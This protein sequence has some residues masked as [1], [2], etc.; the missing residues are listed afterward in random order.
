MPQLAMLD[1][2]AFNLDDISS[3]LICPAQPFGG[4]GVYEI[5]FLTLD[6]FSN[7]N[8]CVNAQQLF[9]LCLIR[10]VFSFRQ[11]NRALHPRLIRCRALESC[12][13][14]RITGQPYAR[15]RIEV[16]A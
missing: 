15:A 11:V 2:S 10:T 7:F 12:K 3:I 13:R 1:G 6:K 14:F 9:A 16:L 5:R 4:T 8:L